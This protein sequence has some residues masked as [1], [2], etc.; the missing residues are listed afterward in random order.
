MDD[1]GKIILDY[2]KAAKDIAQYFANVGNPNK[3]IKV[4]EI[5]SRLQCDLEEDANNRLNE[6]ISKEEK[7]KKSQ[8]N[9][10]H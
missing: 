4:R 3:R 5:S 1:N 10:R 9:R 7:L 8:R 2:D 6:P